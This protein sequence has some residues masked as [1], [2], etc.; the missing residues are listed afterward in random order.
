MRKQSRYLDR[1]QII[2]KI[3]STYF[4]AY[5]V[6]LGNIVKLNIFFMYKGTVSR[7]LKS[8]ILQKVP[9]LFLCTA[10]D[11][12]VF[13]G[14]NFS[15][16]ARGFRWLPSVPCVVIIGKSLLTGSL[17]LRVM[18]KHKLSEKFTTVIHEIIRKNPT[19]KR[20]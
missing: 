8:I 13:C 14:A 10:S 3:K 16:S 20:S 4:Y 18:L 6:E 2:T 5:T 12:F 15:I 19:G 1:V 9:S 7:T 11:K 17:L